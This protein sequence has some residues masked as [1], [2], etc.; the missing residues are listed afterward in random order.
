M[1]TI[2][3]LGHSGHL[4]RAFKGES[5]LFCSKVK[6]HTLGLLLLLL[7]C[8]ERLFTDIFSC[9][10]DLAFR[11][12]LASYLDWNPVY[13]IS[14]NLLPF[15]TSRTSRKLVKKWLNGFLRKM[16]LSLWSYDIILFFW[17]LSSRSYVFNS[18][19][20]SVR[21]ILLD[22]KPITWQAWVSGKNK[23]VFDIIINDFITSLIVDYKI[24]QDQEWTL[25][26]GFIF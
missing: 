16:F 20:F 15:K 11:I 19:H 26:H 7:W 22:V 13:C 14:T 5:N 9:Y 2:T 1:N 8:A 6:F 18:K 23:R 12:I 4:E 25:N 10:Q 24:C 3:Q 21:F 17:M